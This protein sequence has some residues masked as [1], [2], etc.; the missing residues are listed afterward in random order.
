MPEFSRQCLESL[1][2]PLED[3]EVTIGRA[4]GVCQFPAKFMLAASMNPC[5]CGHYHQ[6]DG[7]PCTC[8]EGA[9]ARYR[10]RMSGPLADRLDLQVEMPRQ[11]KSAGPQPSLT[12]AEARG[13]VEEACARQRSRYANARIGRNSELSGA[14]LRKHATLTSTGEQLLH[15]VYERLGLS[16]RAHDRILKM[17]RTIADLAGREAIAPEDVAEAIQY[18]CLDRM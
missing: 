9:I 5:P 11:P 15:D 7:R 8:S 18:R 14:L 13:L 3:R 17:A 10:A 4:R 2:Q 12:T 6:D 1:R 16:M